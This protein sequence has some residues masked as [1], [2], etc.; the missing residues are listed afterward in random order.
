MT[1]TYTYDD[2]GDVTSEAD[3]PAGNTSATDVRCC[4]TRLVVVQTPS[5][6]FVSG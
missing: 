3:T 4:Q 1:C 5:G 2:V 6:A